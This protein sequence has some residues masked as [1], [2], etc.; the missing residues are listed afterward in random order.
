M[1]IDEKEF[2]AKTLNTE[3]HK[4][5]RMCIGSALVFVGVYQFHQQST[6]TSVPPPQHPHPTPTPIV[7]APYQLLR[8]ARLVISTHTPTPSLLGGAV[9]CAFYAGR[10]SFLP[11]STEERQKDSLT[12]DFQGLFS[13]KR[14]R[15]QKSICTSR[16]YFP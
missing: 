5:A 16:N 4:W 11:F 15:L 6:R 13:E 14:S 7:G 12:L 10:L 2:K 8:V 3:A 9:C 1:S